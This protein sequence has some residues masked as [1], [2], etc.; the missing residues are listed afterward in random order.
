M[1]LMIAKAILLHAQKKRTKEKGATNANREWPFHTR[2]PLLGLVHSWF[3]PLLNPLHAKW[4]EISPNGKRTKKTFLTLKTKQ[5]NKKI[6]N[7]MNRCF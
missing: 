6:Q 3:A 7:Q 5:V 1:A 4:L 2:L